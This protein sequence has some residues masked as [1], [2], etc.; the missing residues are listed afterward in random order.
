MTKI[1]T[2][3]VGRRCRAAQEFR[4]ERR[5]CLA[6][7]RIFGEEVKFST[8]FQTGCSLG[9]WHVCMPTVAWAVGERRGF[10]PPG[11]FNR[12]APAVEPPPTFGGSGLALELAHSHGPTSGH[13][14]AHG[15]QPT[16]RARPP[17]I[18]GPPEARGPEVAPAVA[19]G[20]G[21][22]RAADPAIAGLLAAVAFSNT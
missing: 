14:R 7:R 2:S 3:L 17:G 20:A 6:G 18:A 15:S 22:E 21:S 19:P 5:M 10:R 9:L 13:G 12:R 16:S 4:A 8:G 11:A 1:F